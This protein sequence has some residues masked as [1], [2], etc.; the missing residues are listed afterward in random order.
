MLSLLRP[1]A[2]SNQAHGRAIVLFAVATLFYW[3]SL[4]VYVPILPV[5]AQSLGA[6]LVVVGLVVAAYGFSQ[7]ILRI[8][9]GL[10]SDRLGRRKPFCVAGLLFASAGCVVLLLA[11]GPLF[12]IVGRAIVGIS[13]ASWVTITV[14][15]SEWFSARQVAGAM[16]LLTFLSGL[17][18][19]TS[20]SIGGRLADVFGWHSPF[21]V[22][23]LLGVIGALILAAVPEQRPS[24]DSIPSWTRMIQVGTE[25][26]LLRVSLIGALLQ[27]YFW[28]TTYAFVPVYA[29]DL[30]A[31]RTALGLLTSGALVP[32]TLAALA[33]SRWVG[34]WGAVRTATLGLVLCALSAAAVPA[35]H[36]LLLLGLL[37]AVGGLGRG[38]SMPVLL[39]LSIESVDPSEKATAMGVFQAVYAVGMFLGPASA[40]LI[41]TWLGLTAAFLIAATICLVG[42]GLLLAERR[43]GST[44]RP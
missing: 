17:A 38:L 21:L 5:Y 32:Y 33:V 30:G 1:V 35:I 41:A 22:G 34:R 23:G 8:P 24:T 28:A 39:G 37:Q 4:Y 18:Q 6:S 40:G 19:M 2:I 44:A 43:R 26:W 13:A 29:H 3:S 11:P 15:F 7:L 16:A 14:M 36:Q 9:I 25:P 20:M 42:A 10:A 31:T 12:L 27:F